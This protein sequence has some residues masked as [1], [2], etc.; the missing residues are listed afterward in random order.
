MPNLDP[1]P[2]V[3]RRESP[4]FGTAS[5][6]LTGYRGWPSDRVTQGRR[7]IRRQ[8]HRHEA[9]PE[10]AGRM[11]LLRTLAMEEMGD[12]PPKSGH[13]SENEIYF[14]LKWPLLSGNELFA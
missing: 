6:E 10:T 11:L 5:L 14:D 4:D 2:S 12:D 9:I 13:G 1:E 8:I 3:D 7:R